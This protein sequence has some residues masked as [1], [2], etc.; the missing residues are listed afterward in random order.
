VEITEDPEDDGNRGDGSSGRGA[1]ASKAKCGHCR[2]TKCHLLAGVAH[3]KHACPLID[4]TD[5]TK[6]R[7]IAKQGVALFEEHPTGTFLEVMAGVRSRI[8]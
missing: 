6:A 8:T 5:V 2:S 1:G 4:V 7:A 3:A